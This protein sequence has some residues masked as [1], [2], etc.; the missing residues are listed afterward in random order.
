MA[1]PSYVRG[2]WPKQG[3]TGEI[4]G[5]EQVSAEKDV[6]EARA[7][8][9]R[10]LVSGGKRHRQW[11][12]TRPLYRAWLANRKND[13]RLV[14]RRRYGFEV[15]RIPTDPRWAFT[16]LGLRLDQLF[17]ALGVNLALDVGAQVGDY[18]AFLRRNGFTGRIISFEPVDASYQ[19]LCR[20]ARED[21]LWHAV[22]VALGSEDGEAEINVTKS[23]NFSS[24]RTPNAYALDEWAG[25]ADI[26]HIERVTVRR[27][28]TVLAETLGQGKLPATFLKMDTQGWDLE[29][30]QGASGILGDI[31]AMQ[32]EVSVR[33]IYVLMPDMH[34]SLARFQELGFSVSGLFPTGYDSCNRVVEFD[35]VCV[36]DPTS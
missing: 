16:L 5:A 6:E 8:T 11:N 29:V 1:S 34:E 13:L 22:K 35:C 17:S 20:R 18:A 24:F 30:L 12:E 9:V 15:V 19:I 2:S 36:A 33:P 21:D 3:T 10:S 23:T 25:E 26:D 32:S 7:R 28:D 27:L 14:L 4:G 31:V